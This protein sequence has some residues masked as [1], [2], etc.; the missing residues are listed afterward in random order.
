[1]T[2]HTFKHHGVNVTIDESLLETPSIIDEV[3]AGVA[4]G[5]AEELSAMTAEV[6]SKTKMHCPYCVKAKAL[7]E[8]LGISYKEISIEENREE[9]FDRVR[10]ATGADPKTAPQIFIDGEWVGGYDKLVARFGE[11]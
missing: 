4:A 10:A 9:C 6:Y 3:K 1:M 7:L 8:K 2:D 5:M 11:G